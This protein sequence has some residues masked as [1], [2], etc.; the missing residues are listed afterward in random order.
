VHLKQC[1]NADNGV[2]TPKELIGSRL[3]GSLDQPLFAEGLN[4]TDLP[5]NIVLLIRSAVM[6]CSNIETSGIIQWQG[7]A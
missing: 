3:G 4:P 7:T 1:L 6:L 2:S 5:V